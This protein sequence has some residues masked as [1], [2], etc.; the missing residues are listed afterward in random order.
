MEIE[1]KEEMKERIQYVCEICGTEYSKKEK[2][3]ECEASHEKNIRITTREYGEN[4]KYGFPKYIVV[5]CE[6]PSL[7]AWYQ[8][9]RLTDESFYEG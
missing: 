7:S 6:E 4:D 9:H 8:Y 1:E 2:A 5:A 3:E